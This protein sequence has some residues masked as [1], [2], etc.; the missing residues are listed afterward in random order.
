LLVHGEIKRRICSGGK[1]C[2]RTIQKA[3]VIPSSFQNSE[4]QHTY[5]TVL[6]I[7]FNGYETWPLTFREEHKLQVFES[8]TLRKITG[9]QRAEVSKK[10][11]TL[12]N[13]EL[14]GLYRSPC[15]LSGIGYRLDDRGS[16]VRFPAGV[17]NF[18]HRRIQN[19]S[20]AHLASYPMSTR[21]SFPGGKA[22]GA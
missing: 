4:D 15:S 10:F 6:L 8:R 2:H 13:L 16:R 11:R 1:V 7:V 21:G 5:K 9:L 18:F 12:R 17:G 19:G 3:L 14:R 22:A 20:G